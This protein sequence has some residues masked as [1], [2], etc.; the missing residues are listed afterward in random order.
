[1]SSALTLEQE[2]ALA[3]AVDELDRNY[4]AADT[5]VATTLFFDSDAFEGAKASLRGA[6]NALALLRGQLLQ[7]ARGF[8]VWPLDEPNAGINPLGALG[9]WQQL[10]G[11]VRGALDGIKGYVADWSA[12]AT[13][14]KVGSA[15][16]SNIAIG[17]SVLLVAALVIAGVVL[18]AKVAR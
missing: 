10:A 9:A 4:A 16:G 13:L 7:A 5:L 18:F 14:S 6:S 1:M 15:V 17:S 3:A 11:S 2:S 12:L 8:V